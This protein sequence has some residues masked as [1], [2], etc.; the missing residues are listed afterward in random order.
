MP[1]LSL[2]LTTQV[3]KLQLL[4]IFSTF[5]SLVFVSRSVTMKERFS[6]SRYYAGWPD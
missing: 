5:L 6:I 1:T 2:K 4:L 3:L